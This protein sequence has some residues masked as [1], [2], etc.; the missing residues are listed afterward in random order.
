MNPSMINSSQADQDSL[1]LVDSGADTS[2]IGPEFF[3]EVQ[4]DHSRRV[5]IEGFGG[6]SHTIRNMRFGNGITALDLEEGAMLIRINKAVISPYK[7][8]I[9][10][11]QV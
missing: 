11:S 1:G 8:I 9:S 4:H 10:T 3:I 7:T 2:M 6:P 5:S